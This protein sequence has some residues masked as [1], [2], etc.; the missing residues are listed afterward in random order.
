MTNQWDAD[1][2]NVSL[3]WH[4]LALTVVMTVGVIA[5]FPSVS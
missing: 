5:G 3:Y 2:V 4:F 1:I